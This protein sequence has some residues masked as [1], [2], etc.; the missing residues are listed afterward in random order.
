MF[1]SADIYSGGAAE[2]ILGA[3]L[4]GRRDKAIISTKGTFRAGEG[5]NDVGSSR[6]ALQRADRGA[7]CAGVKTDYIDLY[8]TSWLRRDHAHR[9]NVWARSTT[10]CARQ[11]PLHIG[12]SNF[13]GWHLMNSLAISERYGWAQ[14]RRASGLLLPH[15]PRLRVGADAAGCRAQG[16]GD[17]LE[18]ARLGTSSP[19]RSVAGSLMPED[20]PHELQAQCRQRPA[21]YGRDIS[22]RVVDAL[23]RRRA[24]DGQ[25][26]PASCP[27]LAAQETDRRERDHRRAHGGTASP[28]PPAPLAGS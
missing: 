10:W 11:D 24:R 26:G 25:D 21:R 19:A 20:E 5:P 15:W 3:A 12:C 13:S 8:P 22:Y 4:K 27:Q 6:Y 1:D 7:A 23:G 2:E 18:P 16:E 14:A 9:R 17:R 28:E